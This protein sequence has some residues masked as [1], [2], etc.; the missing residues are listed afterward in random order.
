MTET[1]EKIK[2]YGHSACPQVPPM[3]GMLKRVGAEYDYINIH[4]DEAARELVRSINNGYES[5]PTFV[6]PDGS[7]LTE[8]NAWQITKKLEALNYHVPLTA[9]LIGLTSMFPIL[10]AMGIV[11]WVII[12]FIIDAL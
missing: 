10:I 9:K 7:T 11:V 2:M 5:V 3:L 8:P 4:K 12:Q 6:F 1:P